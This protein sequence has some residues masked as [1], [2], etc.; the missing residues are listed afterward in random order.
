M[1]WQV[2]RSENNKGQFPPTTMQ[3]GPG[4]Q[5]QVIRL[6]CKCLYLTSRHLDNPKSFSLG[7]GDQRHPS[8]VWVVLKC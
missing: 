7:M 5:G 6:D 8:F 1:S 2:Y 4:V 3:A